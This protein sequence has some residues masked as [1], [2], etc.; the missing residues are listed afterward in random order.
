MRYEFRA[1]IEPQ[2][3]TEPV[4]VPE[5]TRI[6]RFTVGFEGALVIRWEDGEAAGRSTVA[7]P[8]RL[9]L[10]FVQLLTGRSGIPAGIGGRILARY[11][12]DEPPLATYRPGN[13]WASREY[14]VSGPPLAE[15]VAWALAHL[16]AAQRP[17]VGRVVVHYDR[18]VREDDPAREVAHL[19]AFARALLAAFRGRVEPLAAETGHDPSALAGWLQDLERAAGRT[20]GARPADPWD[21]ALLRARLT[22]HALF[23]ALPRWARAMAEP[24][25]ARGS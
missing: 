13:R 7:A 16:Q 5:G 14:D 25:R 15:E 10:R 3:L 20:A 6:G 9:T 12:D 1:R 23:L 22:A 24:V 4:S 19:L 8:D 11:R 2:P 18:A 17:A 21:P